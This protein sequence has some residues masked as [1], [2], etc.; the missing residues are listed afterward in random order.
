MTIEQY[1]SQQEL[2]RQNIL[3]KI[4]GA[5]LDADKTV[6]AQ[7]GK[8]MGKDMIIYNAPGTF[9]YGL[10][11]VK[12]HISLHLLPIYCVP[13]LNTKYKELLPDASFQKGCIN[14]THEEEVPFEILKSLL[15]ECS[16]IDL[17]KIR[18]DN[19][20]SKKK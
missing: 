10:S 3:S 9:K 2:E 11:S 15:V 18:E 1:I 12:K 14:F 19:L 7:I 13:S 20:K 8:M 6:T 5:I 17:L 4:H 16:K